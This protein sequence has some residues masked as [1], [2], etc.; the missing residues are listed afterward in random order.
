MPTKIGMVSLG[1]PKNQ[2]DAEMMMH[3]LREAGYALSQEA[4]PEEG[5][6]PKAKGQR[7]L[8]RRWRKGGEAHGPSEA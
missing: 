1:C 5:E 6:K 7:R 2:V 3:R 8:R 4:W